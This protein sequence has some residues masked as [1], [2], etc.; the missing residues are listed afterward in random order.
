MWKGDGSGGGGGLK[1][2]VVVEMQLEANMDVDVEVQ[3]EVE[4]YLAV[5]F[6][7]IEVDYGWRTWMLLRICT[8]SETGGPATMKEPVSPLVKVYILV[9]PPT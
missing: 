8:R 4:V 3:L 2:E 7:H 6:P 9:V 5:V 1:L